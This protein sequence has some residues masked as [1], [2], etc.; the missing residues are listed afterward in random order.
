MHAWKYYVFSIRLWCNYRM[1][2]SIYL[3]LKRLREKEDSLLQ[4]ATEE[5][6][7]SFCNRKP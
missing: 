4:L 1:K 5:V 7:D 2:R 6:N 3:L